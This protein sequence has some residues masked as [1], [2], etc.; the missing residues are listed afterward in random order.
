MD[1][2]S[3]TDLVLAPRAM[4]GVTRDDRTGDEKVNAHREWLRMTS[5]RYHFQVT[6][7]HRD[8][9]FAIG[10]YRFVESLGCSHYSRLAVTII[11]RH[12]QHPIIMG[13][14]LTLY[15]KHLN[16]HTTPMQTSSNRFILFVVSKKLAYS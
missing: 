15:I 10:F 16:R 11:S 6:G 9:V 14:R 7:H 13:N 4:G 12:V 1:F 5:R 3:S 8:C 2:V